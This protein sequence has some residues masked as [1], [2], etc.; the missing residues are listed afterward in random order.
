MW[1][2]RG[3]D[4]FWRCRA[5]YLL[6]KG[7]KKFGFSVNSFDTHNFSHPSLKGA[8]CVHFHRLGH[9]SGGMDDKLTAERKCELD[10]DFVKSQQMAEIVLDSEVCV[11]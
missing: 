6:R 1:R 9:F 8:L 3:L 7:G 5:D 11:S 2:K 4:H 10:C